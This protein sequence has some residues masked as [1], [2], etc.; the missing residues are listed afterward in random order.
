[1]EGQLPS[2][3]ISAAVA[4]EPT[5]AAL[6]VSPTLSTVTSVPALIQS[7]VP[8][9][10]SILGLTASY[11]VFTCAKK[12][13]FSIAMIAILTGLAGFVVLNAGRS[14]CGGVVGGVDSVFEGCFVRVSWA[15]VHPASKGSEATAAPAEGRELF[16]EERL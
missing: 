1:M 4:P 12:G 9:A 5:T 16:H 14:P 13:L 6:I 8:P 3:G 11:P 2:P 10:A 7:T 15:V